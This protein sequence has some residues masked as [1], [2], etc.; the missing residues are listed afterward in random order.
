MVERSNNVRKNL[1]T[2]GCKCE[3]KDHV[4]KEEV[5]AICIY[6]RTKQIE[7]RAEEEE[8]CNVDASQEQH[9]LPRNARGYKI[10]VPKLWR[11]LLQ[12]TDD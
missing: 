8:G 5:H 9:Y 11:A 1:Q 3:F 4:G 6:N 2:Q 10:Q 12:D 7:Q